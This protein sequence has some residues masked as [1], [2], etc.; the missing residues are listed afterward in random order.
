[1]KKLVVCATGEM[2]ISV[3][4][5]ST[6]MHPSK[7]IRGLRS[8]SLEGKTIILGVTGSIA[9]V[10]TVELSRELIRRGAEVIAVMSESAKRII[11]PD[12]L[13]YATGNRVI[14]EITGEVEHVRF[15]GEGG[16]A[17]LLLIA[18]ATANTISKISLGID[19]TP[20]TTFAT[21]AIGR[22]LPIIIVPA[23]H[24][25]MYAHE[26]VAENLRNL[27]RMGIKIIPP[28]ITEGTAKMADVEEIIIEVER[29]L[30]GDSLRGKRVVITS[31]ATAESIDPIRILT[32]R[33]SGKTGEELAKEAYR[34]GAEVTLIHRGK[35]GIRGIREVRVESSEEMFSAVMKEMEKGCDIFISAAAVADYTVDKSERKIPSG[36]EELV[37]RLKPTKKIVSEVSR[38]YPEVALIA[39]KAET[40]V[41]PEE[42][43][44]IGKRKREELNAVLIV[45]NDV[46]EGGI[47][48]EEN[49]VYI[50]GRDVEKVKGR[51]EEIA[52]RIWDAIE[53]EL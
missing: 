40:G 29:A 44:E 41:S 39:F 45:A 19:D 2:F 42:L 46:L 20:V 15:C 4:S 22:N 52:V 8:R 51:K 33:S 16:E 26:R 31:G 7:S 38:R 6:L 34:R 37:L 21:T 12:A 35:L 24:G 30:R 3:S 50:I 14:T 1:M 49:E 48:E 17:D 23:M 5:N 11:H 43:I 32:N 18:P 10:K 36:K 9:A 25:S 47:G 27:E 13:H 28:V 53:R